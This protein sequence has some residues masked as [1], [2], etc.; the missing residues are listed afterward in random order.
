MVLRDN[1]S[2]LKI[3]RICL[4]TQHLSCHGCDVP[5]VFRVHMILKHYRLRLHVRVSRCRESQK[6]ILPLQFLFKL[7]FFFV[8]L[9]KSFLS[10]SLSISVF[11]F[12]SMLLEFFLGG[13]VRTPSLYSFF[14]P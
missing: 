2:Q 10:T 9:T 8:N 5:P 12:S 4:K 3:V 7:I 13:G 14:G 1:A 11:A 6:Y